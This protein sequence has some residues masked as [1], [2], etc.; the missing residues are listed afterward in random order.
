MKTVTV[1]DQFSHRLANRDEYQGDGTKT[2]VQFRELFLK[3]LDQEQAWTENGNEIC[4]DFMGVKKIGPSFANEAFAYFT[5]YANP[6]K[7]L[8]KII[9]RHVSEIQKMIIRQE[10]EDGYRR[11]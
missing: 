4:L 9:L 7:I 6:D 2:A 3:H 8:S 11:K 1:K 5:K 10:L